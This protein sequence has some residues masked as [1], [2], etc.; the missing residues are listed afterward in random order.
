MINQI[1]WKTVIVC[2][3]NVN[4]LDFALNKP[5]YTT[6]NTFCQSLTTDYTLKYN[7]IT[8]KDFIRQNNHEILER[9]NRTVEEILDEN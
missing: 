6:P 3:S 1:I 5:D 8:N 2:L 4:N 9:M 7:Y